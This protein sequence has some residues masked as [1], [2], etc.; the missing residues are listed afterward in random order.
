MSFVFTTSGLARWARLQWAPTRTAHD[1]NPP[2][3]LET[4]PPAGL[5]AVRF[6]ANADVLTMPAAAL[7]SGSG[8]WT[9]AGWFRIVND[10][11]A[12]SSFWSLDGIFSSSWHSLRTTVDG[13]SLRLNES[14]TDVLTVGSLTP[15]VW[16]FIAVRKDA[17]GNVKSYLG[18][19][20]GG[21]LTTATGTVTNIATYSGD[22]Y[23]G[24]N[25]YGD[26]ADSRIWG[27]RLWDADLS[28][29]EVDAEFIASTAAR[30]A[31]LRA[32]WKLES[33]TTPGTDSSGNGR[34]LTNTGGSWA[35]EVGPTLPSGSVSGSVSVTLGNATSAASGSTATGTISRT[36]ADTTS[37]GTGARGATGS[38]AQ[39]LANA[40]SAASGSTATGSISRTLADTTSAASGARGAAGS[41]AQ[42]LAD[43]TSA[44][45][46]STATGEVA[47]TL[48]DVTSAASGTA[49]GATVTGSASVTLADTTSAGAG[50]TAT[51]TISKTL[52]DA[53]SSASGARGAA[54]TT[55]ATL[56]GTT[57]A[58]SGSTAAGSVARTLADTTA[59]GAG[60]RG[61]AGVIARTLEDVTASGAGTATGTNT[62]ALAVTLENV[63]SSGVGAVPVNGSGS[64]TLQAV[65]CIGAGSADPPTFS[66][67]GGGLRRM[68]RS[69]SVG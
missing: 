66:S 54:G 15:G 5:Q 16:Y 7:P 61:A 20:A 56:G 6:D 67:P 12:V 17:S 51:G 3:P 8:G 52:A 59:A 4:P 36:L 53:T 60:A 28:D 44:A 2:I 45:S 35:L 64:V 25:A 18:T 47:R 26:W 31:N 1:P 32:Q 62:G 11:N 29:A 68:R 63:T 58:A 48:G 42:T 50:S 46:G 22:G 57:S 19:E 40:T 69:V 27:L 10:R 24:G 41:L 37:A 21:S 55:A 49:S 13:T 38:V 14:G 39:T 33:A 23:V 43:T 65:G 34:D 9:V 30:T